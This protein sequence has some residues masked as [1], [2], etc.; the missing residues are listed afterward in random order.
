MIYAGALEPIDQND[1]GQHG[2]VKGE[3]KDGK[4][5]IQ[6]IPFAGREYIHSSVEVER[7]DTEGSIRK[8]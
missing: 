2:Y 4:A 8:W 5:A 6:W 7:S 1:V 3:L